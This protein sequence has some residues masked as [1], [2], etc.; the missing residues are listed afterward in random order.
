MTRELSEK[1]R[2]EIIRHECEDSYYELIAK[3]DKVMTKEFG[4]QCQ[5]YEPKC[6][7][8]K[9]YKLYNKFKEELWK[10]IVR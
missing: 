1:E 6:G 8:C 10:E 9:I 5:S 4:T 2:A 3:L 7:C